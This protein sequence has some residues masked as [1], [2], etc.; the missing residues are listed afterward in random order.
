MAY[1]RDILEL[2][3]KSSVSKHKAEKG[4]NQDKQFVLS[5]EEMIIRKLYALEK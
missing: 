1:I 2:I 5:N 4:K 3:K